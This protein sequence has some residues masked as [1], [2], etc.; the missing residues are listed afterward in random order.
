M[1]TSPTNAVSPAA[2]TGS[3][4]LDI[5]HATVATFTREAVGNAT[6]DKD[7]ARRLF[8][9]VRDAIRYDPYTVS[10]DPEHYR[11][12]HVIESLRREGAA[13]ATMLADGEAIIVP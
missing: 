3:R 10:N 2:L 6:T 11:A 5:E 7:K 8:T 4:F 1:T 12:S 9:A 13:R